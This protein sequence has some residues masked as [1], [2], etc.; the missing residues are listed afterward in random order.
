MKM[1]TMVVTEWWFGGTGRY[2]RDPMHMHYVIVC[3]FVL[4]KSVQVMDDALLQF[5][6][7]KHQNYNIGNYRVQI[8]AM[9]ST[10][11]AYCITWTYRLTSVLLIDSFGTKLVIYLNI[12]LIQ[13]FFF[14]QIS[15]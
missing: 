14:F 9:P 7:C 2:E 11:S 1:M 8:M 4:Y 13:D 12:C 5:M 15:W 10:L 3:T 6:F